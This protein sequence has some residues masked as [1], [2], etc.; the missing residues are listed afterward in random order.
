VLQERLFA[1]IVELRGKRKAKEQLDSAEPKK[2]KKAKAKE[3]A[4]EL[5]KKKSITSGARDRGATLGSPGGGAATTG[6]GA[7]VFSKF[8]FS[9]A[10]RVSSKKKKGPATAMQKLA[11]AISDKERIAKLKSEDP[12]K[13]KELE[14]KAK[15]KSA[16]LKASGTKVRD[17]EKLLKRT[18]KRKEAAKRRT[19][20]D[21]A[22]RVN[23]VQKHKDDKQ[24]KRKDNLKARAAAK[25]ERRISRGKKP[26]AKPAKKRAGFE[27]ASPQKKPKERMTLQS[28]YKKL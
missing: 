11:K 2:N 15:W 18:I 25:I 20:R 3:V 24:A 28:G 5:A 8:D 19:Q 6:D 10:A 7:V 22:D 26:K 1:R 21:W 13:A 12:D 4:A 14:S 9:T 17:D 16:L 23:T 27:G